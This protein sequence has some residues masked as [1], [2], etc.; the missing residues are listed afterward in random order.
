M[1]NVIRGKFQKKFRNQNVL[2]PEESFEEIDKNFVFW[3][4]AG[5]RSN[6]LKFSIFILFV[7][8]LMVLNI[9]IC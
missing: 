7:V 6:L 9:F 1:D 4:K 2:A 8:G 5:N 3:L